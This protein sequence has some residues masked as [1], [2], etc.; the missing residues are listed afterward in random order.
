M[1]ASPKRD[2]RCSGD[3]VIRT[4]WGT[5]SRREVR[6]AVPVDVSGHRF[7]VTVRK[8]LSTVA[9]AV[10]VVRRAFALAVVITLVLALALGLLIATRLVR[11]LRALRTAA[12]RVAELGPGVELHAD[13]G[14]D[15]V[16]DLTRSFATMQKQLRA[17]EEARR[18]F[19][20]SASHELRTPLQSLLFMLDMLYEDLA[21]EAPD[22]ATRARMWAEPGRR[23]NA[24]VDCRP[25][26]LTSAASMPESPYAVSAS[27]WSDCAA[28]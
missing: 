13:G 8:G 17:Q 2:E 15:E 26:C 5:G 24:C 3:R 12:M 19:V 4:V 20:A 11:R 22:L 27:S 7:A 25:S 28:R 18:T 1:R 14:R 16:G 10:S 6:V 9:G 21:D 23:P